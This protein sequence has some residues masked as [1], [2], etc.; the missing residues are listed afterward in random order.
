[1]IEISR[2]A[3]FRYLVVSQVLARIAAGEHQAQAIKYVSAKA[4]YSPSDGSTRVV[5]KR[6]VYRWL[7]EYREH[8]L[9]GLDP[10]PRGPDQAIS[11]VLSEGFIKLLQDEKTR[12][13][14]TS[15][16][17]I[18][19]TAVESGVVKPQDRINRSTVY[20]TAKK[21]GLPVAHRR[22][23]PDEDA[24]RFAYANRL[25]MVLADGKHFRAGVTRARRVAL[26][27]L[28]DATRFPLGVVVGTSES[29]ELFLHGLYDV[30]LKY[31]LI[32][33]VYLDR[34]PGFVAEDT[35][36]VVS[37]L[38]FQLIHGKAAYP[39]GHG[40]IEKFNQTALKDLLRGLDRRPDVDPDLR[41]LELRIRHYMETQ[42]SHRPHESLGM[43]T[44]YERFHADPKPLRFPEDREALRRKFE[45][46]FT[47]LV[48][49]DNVVS[50][51]S[52]DYDMPR[53]HRGTTVLLHRKL[54]DAGIFFLHDGRFIELHPV[55]LAANART[56]RGLAVSQPEDVQH[57]PRTSAADLAFQRDYGPV[58]DPD[59]GYSNPNPTEDR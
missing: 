12:D 36:C 48:T 16:P 17:E 50:V 34:G 51:D 8:G 37:N 42:Y 52:V 30:I 2:E 10:C 27:F 15:I 13:P 53:G 43:Q 20:R 6:T 33:I 55:D 47:R 59:G 58:V 18:I 44:P 57:P 26:F 22:T 41:A 23:P 40:K 21:L 19:R 39:E 31:G 28:D 29:A 5:G 38:G 49:N 45:V 7:A 14:R 1:M 3:L 35:I 54:L 4:H 11:T 56:K 25:E 46:T 24:R 9:A 32:G